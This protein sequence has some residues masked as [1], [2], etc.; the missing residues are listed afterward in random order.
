MYGSD[1]SDQENLES[2]DEEE[3]RYHRDGYHRWGSDKRDPVE[4]TTEA[5]SHEVID[6]ANTYGSLAADVL[7]G[8][9]SDS[10]EEFNPNKMKASGGKKNRQDENNNKHPD[11]MFFD[12][13]KGAEGFPLNCEIIDPAK[14]ELLL[15]K[16]TAD[17]LEAL[18][19]KKKDGDESK[20]GEA[21][22]GDDFAVGWGAALITRDETALSREELDSLLAETTFD[23]LN[24][25]STALVM[26]PGYRLK[27]RLNDLL[28]G[29][30][31]DREEREKKR[32][33]REKKMSKYSG[34]GNTASGNT[35]WSGGPVDVWGD[36]FDSTWYKPKEYIN[37]YT[38]TMDIKLLDE[39]P[40]DG[41]AL[42]Q[43]ALVHAKD[44]K[45]SGKTTVSRSEG[46]CVLNQSGGVGQ[47]GSFG[48]ITKAKVDVDKWKRIVMSVKTADKAD[49][50]AKGEMRTWVGTEP[51]RSLRSLPHLYSLLPFLF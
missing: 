28:E 4:R 38:I 31:A 1:D 39:P 12:F 43:T 50:G 24:D 46:E 48:D 29:G 37:E 10:D 6:V 3:D 11:F 9:D 36:A 34:F 18:K 19:S 30:D 27:L 44:N 23:V 8:E 47:L 20:G 16:Q 32:K 22:G 35:V 7:E 15:E 5:T 25:G 33:N 42:Y 49:K 41:I 21:G 45:R 51:G 2:Y 14:A 17:V 26:K 40:R 13:R